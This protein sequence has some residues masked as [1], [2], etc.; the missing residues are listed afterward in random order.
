MGIFSSSVGEK[1]FELTESLLTIR[2]SS[3]D[4]AMGWLKS[5]E[6]PGEV[7][8]EATEPPP[9]KTT[10]K[11]AAVTRKEAPPVTVEE[12]ALPDLF[13]DT[14]TPEPT[15]E[16]VKVGVQPE[17]PKAEAPKAAEPEAEAPPKRRGRPPGSK[18][19]V[20]EATPEP[21][22]AP[23]PVVAAKPIPQPPA[24]A[25]PPVNIPQPPAPKAAQPAN[26]APAAAAVIKPPKAEA[27]PLTD[28]KTIMVGTVAWGVDVTMD[29]MGF[30]AICAQIPTLV[31][32]G[33]TE[34]EALQDIRQVLASYMRDN[35][36]AT[37]PVDT[38]APVEVVKTPKAAA[39]VID[40]P[41][42]VLKA[43][44]PSTAIYAWV[45]AMVDDDIDVDVPT[46]C[47]SLK[48]SWTHI[49]Q[50]REK[51]VLPDERL[52]TVITD[53]RNRAISAAEAALNSDT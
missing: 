2:F 8:A 7:S 46:I 53:Y 30:K 33:D 27:P 26:Q 19:K 17:P 5:V 12:P 40:I 51:A 47:A 21:E 3:Y 38:E 29:N 4:E 49:P 28:R 34:A 6:V 24:P 13:E 41:E 25:A 10:R 18:N 36:S 20:K 44:S 1:D 23:E 32:S 9:V 15:P 11:A 14:S 37:V 52:T 35:L 31:G 50:T 16:P 48:A 42:T 22:P 39:P 43:T 45:A